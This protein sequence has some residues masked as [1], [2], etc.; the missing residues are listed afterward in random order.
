MINGILI[1][2]ILGGIS[3]PIGAFAGA[4][5]FVIIQNFAIDFIDRERFNTMIGIILLVIVLFLP[6]GIVGFFTLSRGK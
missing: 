4:F 6:G 3:R 2:A 1:I 5:L